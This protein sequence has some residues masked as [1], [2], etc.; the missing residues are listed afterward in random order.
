MARILLLG[1]ERERAAGIR[2]LLAAGSHAVVWARD[3]DDWPA[4]EREQ[5]PDLVVAAVGQPEAVLGQAAPR[6][7]AGFPPPILFVQTE[8]DFHRD[9]WPRDRIA[10]RIASPFLGPELLARVDALL[11]VRQQV[12]G[13]GA[14]SPAETAGG[15][16]PGLR[17]RLADW[18]RARL[19]REEL[20]S[21]PYLE[22]A[23]RVAEWADRRDAFAPGHATRVTGFCAMIAD[24]LRMN[25][26]ETG[27]LL[28][29][30]MLHD[31]GKAGLPVEVL[32]Q[33]PPLEDGQRRLIRTHPA[34]G[35]ALLRALD[36]DEAVANVVLYHHERPDGTGY[37]R[38]EAGS[39]PRAAYALA[40]AEV[41][42]AMTS[43]RV[44]P[45]VEPLEALERLRSVRGR[46]YDGECVEVLD[47]VL[48]PRAAGLPLSPA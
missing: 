7:G 11:R 31:I 22:V 12:L 13:G 8:A 42:D 3:T 37:Y 2:T 6:R 32:W 45:A 43:S 41:Y 16:A 27:Q 48:R 1:P 40:V 46:D 44:C 29:A 24:G 19:P 25:E 15:G 35:A 18:L 36:P 20:P 4:I 5:R 39:V 34:R 23:A 26:R 30:A 10:D 33:A 28:R 38:T 17:E 9:L 47:H 14:A 21:G